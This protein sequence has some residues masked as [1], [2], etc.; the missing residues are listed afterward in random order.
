MHTSVRFQ[1]L[2]IE[3]AAPKLTQAK[4]RRGKSAELPPPDR[5][6]S[7]STLP[8]RRSVVLVENSSIRSQA[9][10]AAAP[11]A[12]VSPRRTSESATDRTPSIPATGRYPRPLR[13]TPRG[14]PR[15]RRPTTRWQ[16]RRR[17]RT[18]STTRRGDN[19]RERRYP[20]SVPR[21]K[22]AEM[23]SF[24]RQRGDI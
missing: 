23:S 8:C 15:F 20:D 12:A 9:W 1:Q 3:S 21:V 22:F 18:I 7:L 11:A 17:R 4:S 10:A 5:S 14:L 13:K 2:I 19:P 24:E 6:I 16:R